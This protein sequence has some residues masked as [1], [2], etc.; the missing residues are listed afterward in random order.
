MA[1]NQ[2]GP[3]ERSVECLWIKDS[4]ES[5]CGC[6]IHV[7]PRNPSFQQVKKCTFCLD[8]F[9]FRK[10]PQPGPSGP[11]PLVAA[12]SVNFVQSEKFQNIGC[13]V[14]SLPLLNIIDYVQIKLCI[15]G[16][17]KVLKGFCVCRSVKP[18]LRVSGQQGYCGSS[19][20][21][22]GSPGPQDTPRALRAPSRAP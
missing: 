19:E 5:G 10:V 18:L 14:A 2:Y 22:P 17:S 13:F 6:E 21:L 16:H 12:F 15:M 7:S 20:Y 1:S 9:F 4:I 8:F 11:D 3:T